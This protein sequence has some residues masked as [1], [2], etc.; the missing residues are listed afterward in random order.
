MSRSCE[1]GAP[2]IAARPG[3]GAVAVTL[4]APVAGVAWAFSLAARSPSAGRAL[5]VQP[6]MDSGQE[7]GWLGGL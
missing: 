3:P 6:P 2:R 4:M 5:V 7:L 1:R